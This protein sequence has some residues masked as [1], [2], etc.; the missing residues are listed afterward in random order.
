MTAPRRTVLALARLE[1]TRLAVHPLVLAGLA[2]T[3]AVAMTRVTGSLPAW[4]RLSID[5]VAA[6]LP[7]AAAALLAANAADLRGRDGA[8]AL[9]E[10]MPTPRPARTAALLAAV[11]VPV[12]LSVV[13]V[14]VAVGTI[15]TQR[16]VGTLRPLEL[17][18]APLLVAL[19]GATGVLLAR[20][21]RLP[22]AAPLALVVVAGLIAAVNVT[23]TGVATRRRADWL[24]PYVGRQGV[25]AELLDRPEAWRL[26]YLAALTALV[27]TA[28]VLADARGRSALAAFAVAGT[29]FGVA[30]AALPGAPAAAV[31]SRAA[32]VRDGACVTRAGVTYCPLDG[33]Q[34]WVDRWAAA[35]EPV[36]AVLPA[37][38]RRATV[39]QA[40]TRTGP[41]AGEGEA[42]VGTEWRTG[43]GEARSAVGLGLQYAAYAV[44]LSPAGTRFDGRGGG[45]RLGACSAAGQARAVVALWAAGHAHAGAAG[46]LRD[47]AFT[48]GAVQYDRADV[49]LALRLRDRPDTAALVARHWAGVLDPRTSSA[50]LAR[51]AGL[52]YEPAPSAPAGVVEAP[53]P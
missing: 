46:V 23:T 2:G 28:A 35:V 16:P 36:A 44:G 49:D 12:A 20:V 41:A 33:Y 27:A 45:T 37:A 14:A 7:L 40:V 26:A 52:P 32:A 6:A 5:L 39:R 15:A 3:A 42:R 48:G 9:F 8:D 34:P 4:P 19:A 21:G 25:A 11:A 18:V 38:H 50:E 10:P 31:A 30:V 22:V 13:A 24:A 53:C 43:D 17:A 47:G 51:L 29:A 1:G